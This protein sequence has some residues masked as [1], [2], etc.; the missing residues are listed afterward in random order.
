MKRARKSFTEKTVNELTE[1][2][3]NL[4]ALSA[5]LSVFKQMQRENL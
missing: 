1:N 4:A 5:E 3:I 2:C